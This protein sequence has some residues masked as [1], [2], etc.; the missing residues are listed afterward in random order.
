[1]NRVRAYCSRRFNRGLSRTPERKLRKAERELVGR[2]ERRGFGK[3]GRTGELVK[4]EGSV[5]EVCVAR[6]PAVRGSGVG[7]K[8]R[9]LQ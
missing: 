8:L 3:R 2:V 4:I 5:K 9:L 7:K 6:E 1:M